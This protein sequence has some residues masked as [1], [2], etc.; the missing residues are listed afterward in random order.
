[1]AEDGGGDEKEE[2]DRENINERND[3]EDRLPP[4]FDLE[5]HAE[6]SGDAGFG[7]GVEFDEEIAAKA[8]EFNGVILDAPRKNAEG[9]ERG[10][11]DDE[12]GDGA[13][14]R[15]GNAARDVESLRGN[16]WLVM[17]PKMTMRP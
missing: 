17:W 9:D 14:E 11:G 6:L 3:I 12:A 1:M 5:T 15:L 10:D 8:L 13:M 7:I 4:F 2:Q 16:S